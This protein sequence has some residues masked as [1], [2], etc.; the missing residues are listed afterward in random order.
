M[1][2]CKNTTKNNY[3]DLTAYCI[4]TY[5]NCKRTVF[6]DSFDQKVLKSVCLGGALLRISVK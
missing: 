1:V 4:G 6:T 3:E 2:S 5:Q